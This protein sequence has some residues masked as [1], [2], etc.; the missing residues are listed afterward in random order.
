MSL[1]LLAPRALLALLFVVPLVALYILKVRRERL[2]VPS[3]SLWLTARRDHTARSP[4]RRLVR[5]TSLLLQLAAIVLSALAL[6]R[7]ALRSTST[8]PVLVLVVDTSASMAARDGATTRMEL[9]R[10]ASTKAIDG[11]AGSDVIVIE[12]GAQPARIAG[13]TSDAA[14]LRRVVDGLVA[15]PARGSLARAVELA[16]EELASRGGRGRVRVI[17]DGAEPWTKSP[18]L[19]VDVD[20]IGH[21][22]DNVAVTH[23]DVRRHLTREADQEVVVVDAIVQSFASSER[24]VVAELR[25]G[26]RPAG[27]QAF[28]LAAGAG[29][30]VTLPFTPVAGDAS[31]VVTLR[32]EHPGAGADALASDDV[33]YARVPS[34]ATVPVLH[35]SASPEATWV[36][37]ALTSDRSLAVTS[38]APADLGRPGVGRDALV[39]E[40]GVCVDVPA[41]RAVI[42]LAPPPGAPCLGV[43]VAQ[44][45]P[46]PPITS[47]ETEHP[48]LRFLTFDGVHV[49]ESTPLS[50]APTLLRAGPT[51][52]IADVSRPSRP[53]VVIGFAAAESD[54]PLRASFVLFFH[55]AAEAVRGEVTSELAGARS[56]EPL[57]V[58]VPPEADDVTLVGPRGAR[59]TAKAAAGVATFGDIRE[60]GAY[61]AEWSKP[62][63]GHADLAVNL[64]SPAESDLRAQAEVRGAPA[65]APTSITTP[66]AREAWPYLALLALVALAADALWLTRTRRRVSRRIA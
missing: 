52:L 30:A 7:P 1:T 16:A 49:R 65:S 39:V 45:A 21:A 44:P 31:R 48:L 26:E 59:R 10:A 41:A 8:S 33:A 24:E 9:A 14:S 27:K 17:T 66:R 50:G 61:R 37:R 2:V 42:V 38:A 6:A 35:A 13:P 4:F 40:E 25:V 3:T 60:P 34:A 58:R 12:A 11:R 36:R 46:A 64:M 22:V 20:R 47:W 55:N 43:A 51:A 28:T 53:G 54:W 18:G 29:H 63:A 32:I 56:G 57:R 19:A 5:E 23:I 62:L 15:Q